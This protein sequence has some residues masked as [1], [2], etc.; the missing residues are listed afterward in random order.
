MLLDADVL[1]DYVKVDIRRLVSIIS[2]IGRL[3][4]IQPVAEEV[5]DVENEAELID[6]G[7]T[8][9]DPA[10]E[11]LLMAD[12]RSP[13]VSFQDQLCL[14]TAKRHDLICVTNDKRL[15][16]ECRRTG[17][18]TMRG[19]RPLIILARLGEIGRAD[20]LRIARTI[21][22][23]NPHHITSKILSDFEKSL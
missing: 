5:K 15:R 10:I 6:A 12:H 23:N 17:T 14:L 2:G 20:A 11:D 13:G 7:L 4:V 21:R 16:S 18:R 9:L 8:I 19:L 22:E 1:I 3:F